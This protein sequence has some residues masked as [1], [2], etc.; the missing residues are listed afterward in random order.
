[1]FLK[2]I[3]VRLACLAVIFE[4]LSATM[5]AWDQHAAGGQR[6]FPGQGRTKLLFVLTLTEDFSPAC[7]T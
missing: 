4:D 3:L 6:P 7:R 2:D 1:M 5:R